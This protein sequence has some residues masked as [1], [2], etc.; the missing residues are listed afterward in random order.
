MF[1]I[2]GHEISLLNGGDLRAVVGRLCEAEVRHRGLAASHVTWGGDQDAKDGGVDVRVALPAGTAI[3][4]SIP[5]PQTG[6]QT[7]KPDMPRTEI[8]D[9]MRP[10]PGNMLRPA[11]LELANVSGAYIIV[12]SSGSTS[13]LALKNRRDAMAEAI[14]GTPAEGKLALD[15]YDRS[16]ITTWVRDHAGLIPWVR[17][18]T[19]KP[20]PGWQSYGSWSKSPAG[21]SASYLF[22]DQARIRTESKDAADVISAIEGIDRIRKVLSE[23][24]RIVR[25]VGLSGVGKTRLAEALFDSRLG[26]GALDSS[27]ARS[28]HH[29]KG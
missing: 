21:S 4:G 24:G 7:K 16:R 1:E 26:H 17:E 9:E 27:L 19:G 11:I 22:D 29:A 20:V 2:T 28:I 5:R 15:F 3:E 14:K 12:S 18:L 10:K 6:F 25:L 8:L 23:A 13:D